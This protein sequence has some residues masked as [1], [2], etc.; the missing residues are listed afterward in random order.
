MPYKMRKAKRGYKVY[1]A[2]T[3]RVYS[4]HTTKGK[5]QAQIRLLRSKGE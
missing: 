4:K 1:N 2:R 3:K 5:A